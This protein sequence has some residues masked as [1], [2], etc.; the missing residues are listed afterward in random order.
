M[1]EGAKRA[2]REQIS[3]IKRA[4]G[5]LSSYN[6]NTD[7]LLITHNVVS[8]PARPP[9]VD[10]LANVCAA[11]LSLNGPD[12]VG[13]KKKWAPAQ[14]ARASPSQVP[15]GHCPLNQSASLSF[16]STRFAG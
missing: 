12:R 1:R 9:F 7:N 4:T 2:C 13:A 16:G 8:L 10:R 14:S 15:P 3:K 6:E 5:V 11:F